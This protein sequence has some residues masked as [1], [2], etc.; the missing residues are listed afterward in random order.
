[1]SAFVPH[2]SFIPATKVQRS[3]RNVCLT[4][5]KTASRNTGHSPAAP[6]M[7]TNPGITLD[8]LRYTPV[9]SNVC[10]EDKDVACYMVWQQV[11]GNA[12]V[13]ESEREEAYIAESMYRADRISL[14][15]FVRAV[16][17]TSTYRRRFFECCGPYRAVELNFKHLLGRGPNS[18]AE[19]SEHVQRIVNEGYEAEINS[20]ID[21]DEYEEAF[22]DD[23]VPRMRFKGTY[24]TADEFNRMCALYSAPGTS[25][26]SLFARSLQIGIANPNHVLSLDG[27]GHSSKLVSVIA[28]NTNPS[29]VAV[30]RA[31]PTRPDLDNG[32]QAS[33]EVINENS[34]P[35]RRRVE[36]TLGNY[37]VV[38]PDEE[39]ELG[40]SSSEDQMISNFAKKEIAD[41]EAQ[42]AA[43][44]SKIAE[45]N[46]VV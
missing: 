27:A 17:L 6:R 1:M 22:G 8:I 43:L 31:I 29:F 45:L 5:P 36:V 34:A 14:R 37:M 33:T 35:P 20:Y 13:M 2:S 38:T 4:A 23:Y 42:I 10:V 19:V 40:R 39:A 25:D 15:E 46:L 32:L 24:T 16:A 12:Y 30:K 7:S 28:L 18:Q 26:K 9:V 11:F 3:S 41:A 44:Q 21:S